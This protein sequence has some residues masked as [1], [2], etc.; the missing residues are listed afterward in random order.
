MV[1][2]IGLAVEAR[3]KRDSFS[4]VDEARDFLLNRWSYLRTS[5]PTAVNLFEA[6]DRLEG[7]IKATA[8]TATTPGEINSMYHQ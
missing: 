1:A 3:A 4:S 6:A 2:A 7:L 8:S 5:R